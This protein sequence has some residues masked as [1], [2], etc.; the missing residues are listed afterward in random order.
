MVLVL[1]GGY[2]EV[3]IAPLEYFMAVFYALVLYIVFSRKKMMGLKTQPEFR[4]YLTG[5]WLKFIGGFPFAMIYL[6]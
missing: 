2:G 3:G 1:L 6:F 4:Y 5:L